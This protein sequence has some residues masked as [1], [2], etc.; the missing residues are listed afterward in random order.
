MT[1]RPSAVMSR[2][3]ACWPSTAV[4]RSASTTSF[5]QSFTSV[6]WPSALAPTDGTYG[7][8]SRTLAATTIPRPTIDELYRVMEQRGMTDELAR[9]R[10]LDHNS[11]LTIDKIAAAYPGATQV[12]YEIYG[13]AGR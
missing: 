11:G 9:V 2:S 4:R 13:G 12:L 8:G 6:F 10:A 7:E 5:R 3:V 1:R